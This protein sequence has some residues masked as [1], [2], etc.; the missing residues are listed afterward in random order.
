MST[1]EKLRDFCHKRKNMNGGDHAFLPS[2][3]GLQAT[4]SGTRHWED[5]DLCYC[6]L[7]GPSQNSPSNTAVCSPYLSL[8][9]S[10]LSGVTNWETHSVS[11]SHQLWNP[12]VSQGL[13]TP[14]AVVS[15][16]I[17]ERCSMALWSV[18]L[19]TVS[20]VHDVQTN[21]RH[22]CNGFFDI[23]CRYTFQ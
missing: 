5:I 10:L 12:N 21:S 19:N 11:Y 9:G 17:D 22:R 1:V 15:N 4:V 3:S 8:R 2:Q 20:Q 16:S 18:F 6:R 23:A 14:L 13:S 7:S